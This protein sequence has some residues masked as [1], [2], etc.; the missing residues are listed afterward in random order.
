MARID[1]KR[2]CCFRSPRDCE[3]E[4]TLDAWT[5][6]ARKA[7]RVD[8]ALQHAGTDLGADL[9]S[10]LDDLAG[11]TVLA[12]VALIANVIQDL[13]LVSREQHKQRNR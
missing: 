1:R 7:A 12:Y 13:V 5:L 3:A 10:I 11:V 4:A 2:C 6:R 9:A 8:A